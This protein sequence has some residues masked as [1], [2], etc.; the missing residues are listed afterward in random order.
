MLDGVR[1]ISFPSQRDERGALVVAEL[2]H[3][4]VPFPV[5]RLFWQV[6]VP[7]G[8][9]RGQHAHKT[10][11]EALIPV[12]GALRV[13]VDDGFGRR[14]EFIDDPAVALLLPPRVW[15]ELHDFLPGTALLVLASAPWDGDDY[16]RDYGAFLRDVRG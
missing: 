16:W 14:D 9:V 3:A 6:G 15:V 4:T 12:A 13:S 11:W 7:V 8:A 1:R 5:R 2:E 10:L